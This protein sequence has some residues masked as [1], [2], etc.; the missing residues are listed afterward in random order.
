M[1]IIGHRAGMSSLWR[2]RSECCR[3]LRW[4]RPTAACV[5][6]SGWLVGKHASRRWRGAWRLRF[7]AKMSDELTCAAVW[8]RWRGF[9]IISVRNL[10]RAIKCFDYLRIAT[11]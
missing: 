9:A 8:P 6:Y 4:V 3:N 10:S 5:A 7:A 2:V 11:T 1:N